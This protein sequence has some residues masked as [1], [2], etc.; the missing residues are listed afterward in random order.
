MTARALTG[1]QVRVALRAWNLSARDAGRLLGVDPRTTVSRW[2]KA[3]PEVAIMDPRN[4]LL[5][6]LLVDAKPSAGRAA[7]VHEV[8][9]DDPLL[10]LYLLLDAAYGRAVTDVQEKPRVCQGCPFAC[11]SDQ[12]G[13][14]V[15]GLPGDDLG[16]AGEVPSEDCPLPERWVVAAR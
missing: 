15:C 2:V 7:R 13:G 12:A 16:R 1:D 4:Q 6:Q 10:A 5:V 9:R 8:L 11:W 3:G 14:H